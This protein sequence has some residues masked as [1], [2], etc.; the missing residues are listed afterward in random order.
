MYNIALEFLVNYKK[1]YI[2]NVRCIWEPQLE[3]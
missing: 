3:P 1:L 2:L